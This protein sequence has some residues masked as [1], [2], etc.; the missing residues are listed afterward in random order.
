M[1]RHPKEKQMEKLDW[2]RLGDI[3]VCSSQDVTV[4]FEERV[5]KEPLCE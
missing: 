4:P 2:V 1:K 3:S 5:L